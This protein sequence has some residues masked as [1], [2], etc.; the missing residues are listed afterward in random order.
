MIN[1]NSNQ[2]TNNQNQPLGL[3]LS[4]CLIVKNEEKFI[5]SCLH[6]ILPISKS[7][8]LQI[9]V[10]DTGS[11]D[12]T[13]EKLF[14]LQKQYPIIEFYDFL[15]NNDFSEARNFSI[16]KA[17]Y[18]HILTIDADEE[19]INPI[20]IIEVMNKS[21]EDVWLVKVKSFAAKSNTTEYFNSLQFRLFKN[22]HLIQFT[23]IIHEQITASITKNNLKV[24]QSKVQILHKGYNL[25]PEEM[26]VK[27]KRNLELL[28]KAVEKNPYDSYSLFQ[29]GKTYLALED[30]H[31]AEVCLKQALE[32]TKTH[33]KSQDNTSN[34]VLQQIYNYLIST[35]QKLG[36]IND[37]ISFAHKSLELI[38]NQVFANFLLGDIYLNQKEYQN[39]LKYL[40]SALNNSFN[41]NQLNDLSGEYSISENLLRYK[42]GL[43]Y[44]E[45]G[46]YTKAKEQFTSAL[47]K[48][49]KDLNNIFGLAK[50]S[51]NSNQLQDAY[52]W[53]QKA[54]KYY[55][56]REDVK[57]Y[58]TQVSN[59]SN[60]LN[61]PTKPLN[62]N[63]L[64][65]STKT[66]NIDKQ[67][68]KQPK[69]SSKENIVS[70]CMIVKNEEKML[71]ACLDSVKGFV[72]EIIIV[73]TGSV[74]RTKEIALDYNC[75]LFHF[76]WID[77][78]SAARNESIK[79][80]TGQWILY[81]DADERLRYPDFNYLRATLQQA[82]AKIG[83]FVC[84]IISP[85]KS[86]SGAVEVH[87]GA[88][89]RIFRNLVYP[90]IQF[91]GKVHEQITPS[92]RENDLELVF[93][94]VEIEHLGYNVENEVMQQKV[95]RNYK[96][97]LQH[98]Q[99][100]PLNGYA[101]YQ[102][103]QTL[104]QMGLNDEAE[105]CIRFAVDNCTLSNSILSSA[106]ATLANLLGNKKQFQEA[107]NYSEKSLMIYP[108]QVY[109]LNLKAYSLLN[110]NRYE[111][112]LT[113]FYLALKIK[114]DKNKVIKSGF[115]IDL[116]EKIIQNGIQ[117]AKDGLNLNKN[118]LKI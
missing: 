1:L 51:L 75:K 92:L 76:K 57:Q 8:P 15:W 78:F 3:G 16:A 62:Q 2:I 80:A 42:I 10:V 84:N 24:A 23:G 48:F 79:H 18:S 90:K 70:L 40:L 46:N 108:E 87:K 94:D 65:S 112:A 30:Y 28:L 93:S 36:K 5:E 26:K 91:T 109:A 69:E 111:D 101:W 34:V 41:N 53:L 114:Q 86:L 6:S 37:A 110:L 33:I 20:E 60:I 12:N 95:K 4:A 67:S 49:P 74:D 32:I 106:Y 118:T 7:T 105:H 107:L 38:K 14:H 68:E 35:T 43:C 66:S 13:K 81:L 59:I 115:D 44:T 98:V 116:D 58:I 63:H 45:L 73:D 29:L 82:E 19:L 31:N 99:N 100:E 11:T 21:L 64:H 88:Y 102:L 54:R 55:P 104:G 113:V 47:I 117:K 89:P 97:L 85:H 25:S 52:S 56:E 96:L 72:D 22:S 9:I 27:H 83:G 103:G 71:P 39:A 77:D 61:I 17:K 50:I